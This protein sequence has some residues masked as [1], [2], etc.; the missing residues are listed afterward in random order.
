MNA[1]I[2]AKR[3]GGRREKLEGDGRAR[4]GRNGTAKM[5]LPEQKCKQKQ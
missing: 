3:G 5:I 4:V 1:G 2:L